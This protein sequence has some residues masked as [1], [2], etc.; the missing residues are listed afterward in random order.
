MSSIDIDAVVKPLSKTLPSYA[1][2][3]VRKQ[4]AHLLKSDPD[5]LHGVDTKRLHELVTTMYHKSCIEPAESCGIIA[6]QSIGERQTQMSVVGDTL[7]VVRYGADIGSR[8]AITPIGTLIDPEFGANTT[9]LSWVKDVRDKNWYTPSV[10]AAGDTEWRQI[11]ELSRHPANG[12]L[13]K[14]TTRT[15]RSV[16]ATLSHSLLTQSLVNGNVV[17]ILGS[18]VRI[19]TPVPVCVDLP[20]P[21]PTGNQNLKKPIE[22]AHMSALLY[23]CARF[24]TQDSPFAYLETDVVAFTISKQ[25]LYLLLL[26]LRVLDVKVVRDLTPRQL[27]AEYARIRPVRH[28]VLWKN[29][30]VTIRS[31]AIARFIHRHCFVE[32]N[33]RIRI[34]PIHLLVDDFFRSEFIHVCRVRPNNSGRMSTEIELGLNLLCAMRNIQQGG[35]FWDTVTEITPFSAETVY[36]FSIDKHTQTFMCANGLFVHNTLN[37]FH[38]CGIV[39]TVVHAGVPRFIELINCTKDLKN[40]YTR[41]TPKRPITREDIGHS[42]IYTTIRH[43]VRYVECLATDVMHSDWWNAE[44]GRAP[45]DKGMRIHIDT[46]TLKYRCIPLTFIAFCVSK[47]FTDLTIRCSSVREG[48]VDLWVDA[49]RIESPDLERFYLDYL[50]PLIQKLFLCGIKG[51]IDYTIEPDGSVLV[52]GDNLPA[53]ISHP[54]FD[55]RKIYT[56]QLTSI[57]NMFGVEAARQFLIDEFMSVLSND[58]QINKQHITLLVDAMVYTGTLKSV[59]RYSIRHKPSVLARVS[60]EESLENVCSGTVHEEVDQLK[61]VSSHIMTAKRSTAGSG[62]IDII[63]DHENE[64]KI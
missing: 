49:S 45:A 52:N 13:A 21:T 17:P 56:S 27:F 8:V 42:L 22:F 60:F 36:D 28:C 7:V 16:T 32:G 26:H 15:G 9:S 63:Y 37:S 61:T 64:K 11:T 12:P 20:F 55:P 62:A 40:V 14:F 1:I 57:Y 30:K 29:Y 38:S 31:R 6:A 25:E 23:F 43:I 39:N 35:V 54:L 5:A 51:V 18:D 33:Y 58:I 19:G 10:T 34:V 3:S 59:S 48:I 53:L 44:Y 47:A 50:D 41:L 2:E 24:I 4:L 46:E